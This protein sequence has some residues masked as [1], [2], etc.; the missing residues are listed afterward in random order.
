[1][2]AAAEKLVDATQLAVLEEQLAVLEKEELE[3][4]KV[5]DV[6]MDF[7]QSTGL[8]ARLGVARREQIDA[9]L[10][11]L[12]RFIQRRK[13][14]W[15]SLGSGR[16]YPGGGS[17]YTLLGIPSSPTPCRAGAQEGMPRLM[18]ASSSTAKILMAVAA[19]IAV[20]GGWKQVDCPDCCGANGRRR[21][22]W[23]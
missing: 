3:T 2:Q 15:R 17:P 12:T 16:V 8:V 19:Q 4:T 22:G 20:R 13:T 9:I 18:R 21:K 10:R 23:A 5:L 11:R 14:C 7:S 6:A 1:M